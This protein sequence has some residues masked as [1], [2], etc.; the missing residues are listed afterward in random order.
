MRT[1]PDWRYD[2]P[3]WQSIQEDQDI[4]NRRHTVNADLLLKLSVLGRSF[5]STQAW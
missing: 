5:E 3:Q 4:M 1:K 2:L